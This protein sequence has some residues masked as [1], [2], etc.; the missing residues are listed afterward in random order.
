MKKSSITNMT[1]AYN[2]LAK[3]KQVEPNSNLY[4]N[5]LSKI[6]SQKAIPLFWV[7][8]VACLLI[9]CICTA[10]YFSTSKNYSNSRDI[11]SVIYRVNNTLYNE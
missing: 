2:L 10:F 9:T 7:R 8:A 1:D 4:A 5:T 3:I 11:S 6:Q